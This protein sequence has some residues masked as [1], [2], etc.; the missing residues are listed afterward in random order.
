MSFNPQ[1]KR[2]EVAAS[3]HESGTTGQ[4]PAIAFLYKIVYQF[5]NGR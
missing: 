4:E 5:I 1:R 3:P 2:R